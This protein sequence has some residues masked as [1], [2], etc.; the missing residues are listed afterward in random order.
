MKVRLYEDAVLAEI[1]LAQPQALTEAGLT[2][3]LG[4]E[5]A[6]TVAL[7]ISEKRNYFETRKYFDNI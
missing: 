5:R 6:L 2:E 1:T 7:Q 3:A 4:E